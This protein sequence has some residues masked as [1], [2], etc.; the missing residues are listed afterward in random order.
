MPIIREA[1][2][3]DFER[4]YP[5]LLEFENPNLTAEHWRQL[6]ID[7]FGQQNGRF[8]WVL[9]DGDEVVG[10]VSTIMSERTIR[11]ETTQLCNT[12]S[13]IVR[14]EYRKHSLAL[15]AKIVADKNVTVTN[16][17]PTAQVL[18]LLDKLGYTLMDKTERIIL[19][20]LTA[21]TFFD[22]SEILT[23][24]ASL[25]AA[26]EGENLR[27]FH[28]HQLP[29]NRHALLRTP[30]GDCYIMMNR[31]LKA[32]R[33]NLRIPFARVH[34]IG[35]PD[36]FAKHLE[37][38]AVRVATSLKVAALIVD[39][40]MLQGVAPWHSFMRPG[41]RRSAAF[42]SKTLAANDIDGLYTEAVLL[43]Y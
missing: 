11:G 32:V 36:I 26:L 22:R 8:G 12:S 18:A 21:R 40:R 29:F 30:D 5:L 41:G 13:W 33:G 20:V 25:E 38:L 14:P 24:A 16:L 1:R 6:F 7:H 28:D 9:L 2:S 19:P 23:S 34:H 3:D 37:K 31:N 43:N 4:V 10:F 15:H 17:S 42:R 39:D 35:A 27:F